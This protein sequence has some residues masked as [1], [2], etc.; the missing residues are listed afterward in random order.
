[1][2]KHTLPLLLAGAAFIASPV[3]ADHPDP[4]QPNSN[5]NVMLVSLKNDFVS[6][7]KKHLVTAD[8]RPVRGASVQEGHATLFYY[9]ASWCASCRQVTPVLNSRVQAFRKMGFNVVL[10]GQEKKDAILK[11][12]KKHGINYPAIPQDKMHVTGV[13]QFTGRGIPHMAIVSATGELIFKGHPAH[14]LNALNKLK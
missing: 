2:T 14:L 1:M 7:Y 12:M 9:S 4:S 3:Q 10:V 11:Y 8:G 6:R 13:D 5:G